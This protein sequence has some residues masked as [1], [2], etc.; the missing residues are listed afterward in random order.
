[1]LV[2]FKFFYNPLVR[3]M[4]SP[5][6]LCGMWYVPLVYV[7]M[8]VVMGEDNYCSYSYEYMY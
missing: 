7:W 1:M 5:E 6:M 8:R 3:C 4:I 2:S